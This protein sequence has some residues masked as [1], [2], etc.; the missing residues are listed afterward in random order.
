MLTK[1]PLAVIVR[2]VLRNVPQSMNNHLVSNP[3]ICINKKKDTFKHNISIPDDK[4]DKIQKLPISVTRTTIPISPAYAV[5]D[6][7]IQGET[8]PTHQMWFVDFDIPANGKM[9]NSTG[10]VV[11]TRYQSFDH[12]FPL[13][14]LLGTEKDITKTRIFKRYMSLMMGENIDLDA[15]M[16]RLRALQVTT[17]TRTR[18]IKNHYKSI[19][20]GPIKRKANNN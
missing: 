16:V 6:Y 3:V 12:V 5:T 10:Y 18:D 17:A 2:P 15:E 7:F 13:N 20:Q 19:L 4:S 1:V 14:K 8:L 9:K 11:L